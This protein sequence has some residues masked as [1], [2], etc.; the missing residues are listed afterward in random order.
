METIR[1][2]GDHKT[3]LAQ[4]GLYWMLYQLQFHGESGGEGRGMEVSTT[5]P[6]E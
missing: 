1:E 6:G 2:S 3:L 5:V 4:R